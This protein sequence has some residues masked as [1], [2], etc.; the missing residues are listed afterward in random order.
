MR[1]I[2]KL[3]RIKSDHIV[4]VMRHGWRS[5]N[6][7]HFSIYF[8]DMELCDINLEDYIRSCHKKSNVADVGGYNG[9]AV[10]ITSQWRQ[11][12]SSFIVIWKST[13]I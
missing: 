5:N 11:G 2:D 3:C 4:M 1:V 13:E 8:F 12:S 6:S 9:G 7:S 10:G